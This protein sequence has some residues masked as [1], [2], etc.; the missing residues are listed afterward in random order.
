MASLGDSRAVLGR[1]GKGPEGPVAV[2]LSTD[3]NANYSAIRQELMTRLG[4]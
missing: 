2:Q 3:H 1:V 4:T